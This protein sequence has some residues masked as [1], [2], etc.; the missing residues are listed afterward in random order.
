LIPFSSREAAFGHNPGEDELRYFEAGLST[1]VELGT[2]VGRTGVILIALSEG[3][4]YLIYIRK[5]QRPRSRFSLTT[6]QPFY[7]L[8]WRP[9][10]RSQPGSINL[11]AESEVVDLN[12]PVETKKKFSMMAT[13][14]HGVNIVWVA[15]AQGDV[16]QC[17][18][19]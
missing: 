18:I 13:I 11:G 1:K 15:T 2:G 12:I 10:G 9:I 5:L 19:V 7:G 4:D 6:S 17:R 8:L 3:E 14:E 16:K